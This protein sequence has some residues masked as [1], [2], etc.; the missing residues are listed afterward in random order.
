M[1]KRR[2]KLCVE[3]DAEFFE[4]KFHIFDM[5]YDEAMMVK[6]GL[7]L[8]LL[9]FMKDEHNNKEVIGETKSMIDRIDYFIDC[10]G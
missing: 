4:D 2:I 3:G 8:L 10:F 7:T 5:S 9:L 6:K 1:R